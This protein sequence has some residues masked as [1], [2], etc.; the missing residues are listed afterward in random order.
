[1]SFWESDDPYFVHKGDAIEHMADLP[2]A[3]MDFSIFSPP[4]PA[5]YAYNADAADIGNSEDLGPESKIHLSFFYRQFARVLKPG[6]VVMVHVGQ[7]PRMKRSGGEGLFDF[8]GLNIRLGERAGL[9][10]EYDWMVRVD[11]QAQ[12]ILTKS[13]QLK[14]E[15][16]ETD[17]AICRGALPDYLLKFRA[18]GENAVPV[19]SPGEVTRNNWIDWAEPG[20]TDI[21]R[22]NTLNAKRGFRD[23]A[24]AKG[25]DDTKHICVARGSLVLTRDGHRPIE[26]VSVGDMVLTHRGRWRPVIA[27]ACTG[28]KPVVRM[29]AQG[30]ADLRTTPDHRL[31]VRSSAGRGGKGHE[32]GSM[33]PH[34][35]RRNAATAAPEWMRADAAKGHYVNLPL[36]PVEDSPLSVR[37]W[38]IIGRWLGDGHFD[39]RGRA[40]ISS[41]R[42]EAAEL[43]GVMGDRAGFVHTLPT[44]VRQ[45]A[46]KDRRGNHSTEFTATLKRCG[47]GA[48][49]KRLPVEALSLCQEKAEALLS[50]YL[51]ADGHLVA[52]IDRWSASSVSRPLLLGMAMVAQ[53][54]RGVVASVYAGRPARE[55]IIVG[56]KCR[57][58]QDW[59]LG[60]SPRNVSGMVLE[61]GAWK[62]VRS[63]EPAGEAEVWDI[64]VE[65][66][67]SFVVEGCVAH[68]CPLQLDVIERLVRLY[69]NPGEVVFSPF[70]GIG[71]EGV[72][73]LKLGRRFYG[74]ELK[75]EYHDA[76][77]FNLDVAMRQRQESQRTLFDAIAEPEVV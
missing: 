58:R 9:T 5:L 60:I 19:L 25:R 70:A 10:F 8:R 15:G 17:R 64:Q 28:V 24:K 35:H 31:W 57:T 38:W 13:W 62:K 34:R 14:F 51:S 18:P 47:R 69:S 67:E 46:V 33:C 42:E 22:T 75:D 6:R 23:K 45:V 66:D 36:P 76:A 61:D 73:A 68:N 63:V 11:P 44:G 4:F 21:C 56:R 20:W 59:I 48:T 39:T 30:V 71:S 12:A 3:S 55:C 43:I 77:L 53:R 37:D 52:G 54:A 74:C 40:H 2:A 29:T 7:I 72:V 41:A 26:D 1:M 50:G 65:E 49:G 16:L 32:P 27:K